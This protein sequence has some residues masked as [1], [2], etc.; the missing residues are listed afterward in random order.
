MYNVKNV[1]INAAPEKKKYIMV[2]S[3]IISSKISLTDNKKKSS[4]MTAMRK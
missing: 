2:S 3:K 1:Q 4:R